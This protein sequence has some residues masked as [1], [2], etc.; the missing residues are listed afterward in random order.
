MTA[1]KYL[2]QPHNTVTSEMGS[3]PSP[4]PPCVLHNFAIFACVASHGFVLTKKR[5]FEQSRDVGFGKCWGPVL[6]L[7]FNYK[8]LSKMYSFSRV[9]LIFQSNIIP[10][11]SVTSSGSSLSK[12]RASRFL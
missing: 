1:L 11:R 10:V 12:A 5:G 6:H 9:K 2:E 8:M 4:Q 3:V 7:V